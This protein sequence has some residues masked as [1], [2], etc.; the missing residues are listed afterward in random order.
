MRCDIT[1]VLVQKLKVLFDLSPRIAVQI[2]SGWGT[3]EA[4][5]YIKSLLCPNRKGRKGFDFE[6]YC[7]L[8]QIYLMHCADVG[9]FGDPI[10]FGA[11]NARFDYSEVTLA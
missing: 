2:E 11:A 8:I 7:C 10:E 3:E 4:H 6:T 1:P 5:R 9:D